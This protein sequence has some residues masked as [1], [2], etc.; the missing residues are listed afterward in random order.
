[1]QIELTRNRARRFFASYQRGASGWNYILGNFA[2]QSL[3]LADSATLTIL[4]NGQKR[5]ESIT[6][7]E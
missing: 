5:S 1:M 2:Q 3:P 7:S 4:R 6:V